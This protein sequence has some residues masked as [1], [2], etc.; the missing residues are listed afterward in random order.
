MKSSVQQEDG[1]IINIYTPFDNI[2]LKHMKQKF[3]EV[4]KDI[5]S[6]AIIVG[7]VQILFS[8]ID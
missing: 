6:S 8:I 4:K 2:P 3:I 5:E 1:E 7:Y